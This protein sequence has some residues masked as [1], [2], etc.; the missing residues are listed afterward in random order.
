MEEGRAA[1]STATTDRV[2]TSRSHSGG[3][4]GRRGR[5]R[6]RERERGQSMCG[7][8]EDGGSRTEAERSWSALYCHCHTMPPSRHRHC[9][10]TVCW[11]WW[12]RGLA[13]R[14]VT[15]SSVGG[16]K[17]TSSTQLKLASARSSLSYAVSQ[18]FVT[19]LAQCPLH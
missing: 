3:D 16:T 13:S 17:C 19:A 11:Q 6:E 1:S 15:D 18:L 4:D 9:A 7:E 10:L 12:D 5:Q 2:T 8:R 14:V